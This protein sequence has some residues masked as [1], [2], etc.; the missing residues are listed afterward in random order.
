LR[1]RVGHLSARRAGRVKR[2]AAA[3]VAACVGLAALSLLLPSQPSYDPWAWLLW[4]RE[5]AFLDLDTQN[6]PSWKPLPVAITFLLAPLGKLE[7]SL[8][9]ALWLVVAR[10]GAL[11]ALV[12]AFR[13]AGRLAGPD[14]RV[15]TGA[16]VIA[17]VALLLSPNW[18]RYMAHGNEA[19][20][21]VALMLWA[22]DRHLD[23][24]RHHALVLG[25]LACLL[26]PEVFPFLAVYGAV[27]W[28]SR[29]AHRR[30]VAGLALALPA[31]WLVP[32]WIGSGDPLGAASQA[33]SEPSWS[34]S[35]HDQPWLAVLDRW[36]RMAGLPLEVGALAGVVFALRRRE[37][38][39]V[40]LASLA[41]AWLA[42]V[43]AMTEVGFSGNGRYLL[44][45]LVI[46][47]L[48]AGCG[49]ARTVA[50]IARSVPPRLAG[51][52]LRLAA[53]GAATALLGLGAASD[54][55]RRLDGFGRQADSVS[56]L[57]DL[58]EELTLAV[59]RVGGPNEITP[60]GAPT[61]NRAFITHLAWELKVPIR[62]VEL[63]HG[64]GVV[65]TAGGRLSG[66][67]PDV[68]RPE[69]GLRSLTRVGAWSVRRA[70]GT[71]E[72]SHRTDP[73]EPVNHP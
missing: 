18:V 61:V 48:L 23:G 26:R 47:S 15:A 36:Q 6:G 67:P 5:I 30:L 31:L 19:P 59:Q 24:A 35:L 37:R 38:T 4:G 71:R 42:L 44:P 62:D 13:V 66:P 50:A 33:R 32:E 28:H 34:L 68:R 41:V 27:V 8:P 12:L 40:A 43:V 53:A 55:E 63:G 3:V 39:S 16:G 56:P 51:P 64:H 14:R 57:A 29:P 72:L 54:L 17:A 7:D 1:A 22:L 49:A 20:M 69:R 25:F 73:R 70:P 45:P 10:T 2:P 11:L 21:A 52:P 9:P 46:V 58:H 60:H 65:F